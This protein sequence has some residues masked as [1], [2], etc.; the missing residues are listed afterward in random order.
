MRSLPFCVRPISV[1]VSDSVSVSLPLSLSLSVFFPVIP[2]LQAPWTRW[3]D[4]RERL[5]RAP[6]GYPAGA[7]GLSTA[8]LPAPVVVVA[9]AAAAAAPGC[10]RGGRTTTADAQVIWM[11]A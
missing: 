1:S 5:S 6:R 10:C 7:A 8:T 9:A 2:C 11:P 3:G 4:S